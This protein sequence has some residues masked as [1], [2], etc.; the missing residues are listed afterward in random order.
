MSDQRRGEG[1]VRTV[2]V[3]GNVSRAGRESDHGA[4]A[5]GFLNLDFSKTCTNAAGAARSH[6][7]REGAGQRIVAAGIQEHHLNLHVLGHLAHDEINGNGFE[8]ERGFILDRGVDRYQ[9][10]LTGD[11]KAVAGV[12]ENGD[13]RAICLF[14]K[15][16][17]DLRISP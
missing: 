5:A 1:R 14:A 16:M 7:A 9:V 8:I 15:S 6:A 10:I 2:A 13:I 3:Q 11:L 12:E 17:T 4:F